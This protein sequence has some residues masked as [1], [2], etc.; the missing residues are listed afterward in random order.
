MTELLCYD[1]A[2]ILVC[3]YV[4]MYVCICIYVCIYI[5]I[6]V[7]V[8]IYIYIYRE[9]ER[10][11]ERESTW[12]ARE[13]RS[14][15]RMPPSGRPGRGGKSARTL[16][17]K[18]ALRE[19]YFFLIDFVKGAVKGCGWSLVNM[20]S[21]ICMFARSRGFRWCLRCKLTASGAVGSRWCY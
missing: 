12:R 21:S 2:N 4:C 9:R 1:L 5:Y 3:M 18:K 13:V 20:T 17:S 8:Y 6:Y 16:C 7:Y 19:I 15:S 14:A 10:E 11:R